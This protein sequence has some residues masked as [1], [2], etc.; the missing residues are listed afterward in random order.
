MRWTLSLLI[1]ALLLSLVCAE[2][3]SVS[4]PKIAIEIQSPED[5]KEAGDYGT[6]ER[7]FGFSKFGEESPGPDIEKRVKYLGDEGRLT[8]FSSVDFLDREAELVFAKDDGSFEGSWCSGRVVFTSLVTPKVG[9]D[10]RVLPRREFP[11]YGMNGDL[12]SEEQREDALRLMK[13]HW[14]LPDGAENPSVSYDHDR[15]EF[16]Y[17]V[18]LLE[19]SGA[20]LPWTDRP[21]LDCFNAENWVYSHSSH[22]RRNGSAVIGSAEMFL[23]HGASVRLSWNI[24]AVGDLVSQPFVPRVGEGFKDGGVECR[25]VAVKPGIFGGGEIVTEEGRRKV[26]YTRRSDDGWTCFLGSNLPGRKIRSV[27]YLGDRG[28]W[29]EAAA[30]S[31]DFGIISVDLPEAKSVEE[32]P[33]IRIQWMPKELRVVADIPSIGG[34]LKENVDASTYNEIGF[35][36]F[37]RTLRSSGI[38]WYL[39]HFLGFGLE[40]QEGR[41]PRN[42]AELPTKEGRLYRFE[43]LVRSWNKLNPDYSLKFDLERRMISTEKIGKQAE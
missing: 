26:E 16:A 29:N 32:L 42:E 8:F 1:L 10:G 38:E 7:S 36:L 35:P 3:H 5:G 18:S 30:A 22:A 24:R 14:M 6:W 41:N 25:V 27:E 11:L 19:V 9:G 37:G 31:E 33:Q 23:W 34:G 20:E 2:E 13:G 43:D 39:Y 17:V 40:Y 12:L 4:V 21:G 15:L 28:D